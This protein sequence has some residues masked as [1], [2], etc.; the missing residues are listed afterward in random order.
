ME[1][2]GSNGH[3]S[4]L[5]SKCAVVAVFL[6][7]T[8]GPLVAVGQVVCHVDCREPS[9]SGHR[10]TV[11]GSGLG[12]LSAAIRLAVSGW[13]VDVF[14]SASHP[15]GKAGFVMLESGLVRTKNT[16]TICL[17]I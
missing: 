5:G 16:A 11:V 8:A 3:S 14:E 7:G 6:G 10:A 15:G 17:K 12:G 4:R 9:M 1:Q 13:D 2:A